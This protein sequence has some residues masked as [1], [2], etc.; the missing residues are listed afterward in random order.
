MRAR[1]SFVRST[2][3]ARVFPWCGP[4]P[5]A[6]DQ[7]TGHGLRGPPGWASTVFNESRGAVAGGFHQHL[8]L[9]GGGREGTT[10]SIEHQTHLVALLV[11]AAPFSSSTVPVLTRIDRI[12]SL[13]ETTSFLTSLPYILY[14]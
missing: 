6:G 14:S 4:H 9:S 11:S 12:A 7:L 5:C 8:L 10:V 13:G 3:E 1:V 2:C